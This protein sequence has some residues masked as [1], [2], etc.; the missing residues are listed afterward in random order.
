[1]KFFKKSFNKNLF[2]LLI[3]DILLISI[4]MYTSLLFR[5]DFNIPLKIHNYFSLNNL[6]IIMLIKVF[7][8]KFFGLYQGMWRY[9]SIWDMINI[10]MAN[11]FFVWLFNWVCVFPPWF[12]KPWKIFF[13]HRFYNLYRSYKYISIRY[14]SFFL[15]F[16]KFPN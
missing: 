8:Y 1:M 5:F 11:I 16:E 15:P 6:V 2:I 9:T 4:A 13:G 10:I 14:K 3:G 12:S 7:W